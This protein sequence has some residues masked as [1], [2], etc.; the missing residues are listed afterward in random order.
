LYRNEQ[1]NCTNI[2]IIYKNKAYN[3]MCLYAYEFILQSSSCYPYVAQVQTVIPT[4]SLS[5]YQ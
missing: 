5:D 4:L 2:T 3:F 1:K